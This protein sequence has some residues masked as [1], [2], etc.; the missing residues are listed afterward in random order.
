MVDLPH[1][2]LRLEDVR[3]VA[4]G[5][6]VRLTPTGHRLIGAARGR[7]ARMLEAGKPVY[8]VNT[9]FG[10][11]VEKAIPN[12]R[13]CELQENLIASHAVGTGELLTKDEVRAAMFLRANMLSKGFSGVRCRLV[14][15]LT[16]ML[17]RDVVP[18][19][20]EYGSVGA[21]GDLAPL[22]HIA[23][24]AIGRGEALF[25]GRRMSGQAAL[26]AAGLKPHQL[27][28][29]E[30]LSL[31]NGTEVMAGVASLLVLNAEKLVD[32][33]DL[34]GAMTAAALGA[35]PRAFAQ[36]IQ[37]LKPHAGQRTSA[38]NIRKYLSGNRTTDHRIQDA[39]SIRCMPQV[40]GAVRDGIGFARATTETEIN[41]VTDN[42]LIIGDASV[43]GGNFHGAAIALSLDTLAIALTQAAG[44]SERRTS[45]LLDTK[46]SNLP[47]FLT[48]DAGTNSGM[49]ISQLLVAS[50]LTDCR[51]F[52]APASVQSVPTS[53]GQED[54]V[55]MGMNSALKARRLGGLVR[56]ILSVELMCAVQGLE[57]SG[58]PIPVGL[59]KAFRQVRK[60]VP[61]LT[62]D[63]ELYRD[64]ARLET[65]A[66]DLI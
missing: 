54:F 14:E 28:P 23:L 6:R 62:R 43:S 58:R 55:S 61:A 37:R 24:A 52:S 47:P 41:S 45:R 4:S 22:A 46:L 2:R 66:L 39:Y 65:I 25:R 7:I 18:V 12:N 17:N 44:I 9:G 13:L 64:I 31:I 19:V 1:K 40:H 60:A 36:D 35:N 8:G 32:L 48:R 5:T 42:P 29:K 49:M 26:R 50:M 15:H 11:L 33:A 16:E 51:M 63:R 10:A 56:T 3:A 57:L 21:S 20:Y 27:Q 30:G 59:S 38:R 34:V 53:A